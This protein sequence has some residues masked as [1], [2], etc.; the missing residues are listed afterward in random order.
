MRDVSSSAHP[1]LP[2]PGELREHSGRYQ[3][4]ARKTDDAATKRQLAA[5]ALVLA[6]IAEALAREGEAVRPAKIEHYR[7]LLAGPLDEKV[8]QVV[9]ELLDKPRATSHARSKI[10]VW[11]VRAE[12]LR[13]TADGFVVPSA[14][15]ALR[16]AAADYD[17]LADQL[18]ALLAGCQPLPE[19][20]AG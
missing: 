17:T 1:T 5:H 16:V 9:E 10:K 20:K 14:R 8:R 2:A 15:D 12:E 19:D 6:Q 7:G 4:A 3:E 18:E 13:T 11:R